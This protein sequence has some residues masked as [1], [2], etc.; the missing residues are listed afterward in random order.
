M[1]FVNGRKKLLFSVALLLFF[2]RA[3]ACASI[4]IPWRWEPY[5]V[6]VMLVFDVPPEKAGEYERK[7]A[8]QLDQWQ[9]NWLSGICEFQFDENIPEPLRAAIA[10]QLDKAAASDSEQEASRRILATFDSQ[11]KS[12]TKDRPAFPEGTPTLMPKN[13]Q[14]YDKI[15]FVAVAESNNVTGEPTQI[16]WS[17]AIRELDVRTLLFSDVWR[18]RVTKASQLP[19]S[20]FRG[21]VETL[22]PIA[23]V[24]HVRENQIKL[25]ER[26]GELLMLQTV[27]PALKE[28]Q[29]MLPV[30]R[31]NDRDGN[32]LRIRIVDWTYFIVEKNRSSLVDAE[33]MTG[34]R[35]PIS[36]RR[37]STHWQL[38]LLAK[39][40]FDHTTIKLTSYIT[41]DMRIPICDVLEHLPEEKV[42]KRIGE[43]DEQGEFQVGFL[44]NRPVRLLFIRSGTQLMARLPVMPG[45]TQ[46]MTAPI[47]IADSTLH[48][49]S[50]MIGIQEQILD[51]V[52]QRQI[53]ITQA[54]DYRRKNNRA[55]FN[56]TLIR[57]QRLKSAREFETQLNILRSGISPDDPISK[58]RIENMLA[59][60]KKMA[61]ESLPPI[62]I[63]WDA[64]AEEN[65]EENPLISSSKL[66][67]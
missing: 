5:K 56:E 6:G 13:R 54:K 59:N 7:L 50:I 33:M 26:A 4:D 65:F 44:P 1:V 31:I 49:E 52:G 21:I 14:Q 17:L 12:E 42:A 64:P 58:R 35:D 18:L 8:E 57:I 38:A 48:A 62:N 41:P 66:D 39:P 43:T 32:P 9:Q 20:V 37:R 30:Q 61:R 24:V 2:A 67:R 16:G 51:A 40:R 60:T 23:H 63:P 34:L 46:V 28:Q 45:L 10:M 55:A 25:E 27:I 53:L 36:S 11:A 29:T 22:T 15:F 3:G 19:E 47:A